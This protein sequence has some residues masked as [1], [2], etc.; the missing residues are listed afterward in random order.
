MA[1]CRACCMRA[2]IAEAADEPELR[3]ILRENAMPGEINISLEREPDYFRAAR[4]GNSRDVIIVVRDELAGRI[5]GMGEVAVRRVF[6]NGAEKEVGYLSQLRLDQPYRGRG[7]IIVR[8]LRKLHD[9]HREGALAQTYISTI[10]SDNQSARRLLEQGRQRLPTFYPLEEITSFVISTRRRRPT[11]AAGRVRRGSPEM[12][13]DIVACLRRNLARYQ[14]ASAWTVDDLRSEDITR[15][16]KPEDFFVSYNG[17]RITGCLALWDQTGFKQTVVRGYRCSLR[18]ARPL[19]NLVAPLVQIPRLPP[20]GTTLNA[21]F[22]S[23]L[24]IDEEDAELF[25][26]LLD[27]LYDESQQRGLDHVILGLATRHP[28]CSLISKTFACRAYFSMLYHVIW[29]NEDWASLPID[30]RC[31]QLEVALL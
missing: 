18:W 7:D 14:F 5:V 8:G 21:A 9:L 28:F 3:R 4:V 20:V 16:L 24:A 23:H 1:A 6:L 12:L 17:G 2:E 13:D 30:S 10:V 22:L 27:A 25:L 26:D 19:I 15:D 11:R 31:P 29:P